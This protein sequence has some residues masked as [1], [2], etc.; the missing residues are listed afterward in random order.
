M[1]LSL[2]V[3]VQKGHQIEGKAKIKS[4]TSV[5][6]LEMG[7]ILIQMTSDRF[8]F[9]SIIALSVELVK[10]HCSTQIPSVSSNH[11]KGANRKYQENL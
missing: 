7:K 6:F 2:D 5:D 3:F 9:E 8:L 1:C 4:K 10:P 11:R